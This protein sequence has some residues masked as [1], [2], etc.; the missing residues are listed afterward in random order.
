MANPHRV[1]TLK[2]LT[3][4][5][6]AVQEF[7]KNDKW[8]GSMQDAA[9]MAVKDD[10]MLAFGCYGGRHRSVAMAELTAGELRKMG[11]KVEVIHSELGNVRIVLKKS[12]GRLMAR[13][14][15]RPIE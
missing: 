2:A 4:R 11:H 14:D 3:G 9:T 15:R 13:S 8:F 1:P 6:R 5:D 7:V 10:D 12:D